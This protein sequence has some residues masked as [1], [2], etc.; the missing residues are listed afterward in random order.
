MNSARY[1]SESHSMD[2]TFWGIAK[3]ISFQKQLFLW[4]K[5]ERNKTEKLNCGGS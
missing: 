2:V 1:E 4:K 5:E 3:E